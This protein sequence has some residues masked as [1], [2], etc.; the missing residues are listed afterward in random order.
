MG[1]WFF[2]NLDE[3]A[4]FRDNVKFSFTHDQCNM[5]TTS[6]DT[7]IHYLGKLTNGPSKVSVL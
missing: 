6:D 3:L 1:L 2:L 5:A 7:S 4:Y